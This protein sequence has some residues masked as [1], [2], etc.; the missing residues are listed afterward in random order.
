MRKV[1]SAV[2]VFTV[3]AVCSDVVCGQGFYQMGG[4]SYMTGYGQVN[5]S[6][7]YAMAT[8]Q[9][10]QSVQINLQRSMARAAMVKKWG[11]AAVRKAEL[12]AGQKRPFG[13]SSSQNSRAS[14]NPQ[15]VVSP[16]PPAPKFYGKYT[17]VAGVNMSKTISEALSDDLSERATLKQVLDA[18]KGVYDA[19]A[20]TRGWQN[21]IAGGMTFFLTMMATVHHDSAEPSDEVVNAVYDAVNQSVDSIPDFAKASNKDKQT[22]NEMLVGYAALPMAFYTEAKQTNDAEL[23]KTSKLL[24]GEMIKMVLKVDPAQ[25][26][27]DANSL[28]I[29]K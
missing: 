8:Q 12:E 11:E 26:K 1:V 21:N 17:P 7:G 5:G 24:A 4:G 13:A 28:T 6:F 16:P 19:E 29:G 2:F 18:I 14:S 15:I 9:M 27:F 25:V 23:L 22:M 10:Y 3:L 20:K